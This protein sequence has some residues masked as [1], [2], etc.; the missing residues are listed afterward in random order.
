[1]CGVEEKFKGTQGWLRAFRARHGIVFKCVSGEERSA[2]QD[3]VQGWR[4]QE[5][6]QVLSQ[7]APEDIFNAD[8]TALFFKLLPECT[9]AVKNDNC[10]GG[11]KSKERISV[12][13]CCNMTGTAKLKP[14]VIGKSRNPRAFKNVRSLPVDYRWNQKAWMT[15]AIFTEWLLQLE[16]KMKEQKRHIALIL[17]NCSAHCKVPKM[18]YVTS[19]ASSTELYVGASTPRPRHYSLAQVALPK[20]DAREN[21]R[22][23]RSKSSKTNEH[24]YPPGH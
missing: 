11:K 15:S 22:Q 9:L 16:K 24:R 13:L 7:Y 20:T 17:D 21:P 10:K 6:K 2:P 12:L 14:L 18:T 4:D 1:M 3:A 8:E 5:M 19:A 23:H